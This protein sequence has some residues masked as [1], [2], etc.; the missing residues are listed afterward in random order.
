M[1]EHADNSKINM[2][3]FC[4]IQAIFIQERFNYINARLLT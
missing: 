4:Y 3:L 1:R 2:T